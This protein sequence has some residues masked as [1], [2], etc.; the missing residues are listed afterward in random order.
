MCK[1]TKERAQH[2]LMT[3]ENAVSHVR[4]KV[5]GSHGKWSDVS[6]LPVLLSES[7]TIHSHCNDD[8]N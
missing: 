3:F 1:T 6:K 4:W 8:Y 2:P 7:L 5:T